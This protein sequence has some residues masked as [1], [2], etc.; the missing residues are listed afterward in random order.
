MI[1]VR[2]P[3]HRKNYIKIHP[4]A[5]KDRLKTQPLPIPNIKQLIL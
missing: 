4:S 5:Q 2:K 1:T 3:Q